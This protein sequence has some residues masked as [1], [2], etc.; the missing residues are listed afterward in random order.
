[1]TQERVN[2]IAAVLNADED[3]AKKLVEMEPAAAAE[4]L[5]A[6]G[7]DF[8]ADELAEFG[9]ILSKANQSGELDADQL[10]EVAGGIGFVTVPVMPS[11]YAAK[12]AVWLYKKW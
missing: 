9:D 3:R 2:A 4:A 1:M 12:A 5:K 7:Y 10:D 8:T 6:E 11:Y